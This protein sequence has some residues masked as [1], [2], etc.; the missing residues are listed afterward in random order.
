MNSVKFLVKYQK[1]SLTPQDKMYY[2][3]VD[4][5]NGLTTSYNVKL[6]FKQK[7]IG[8]GELSQKI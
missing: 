3:E 5:P 8:I 2:V 1:I 7:L 6:E 4:L